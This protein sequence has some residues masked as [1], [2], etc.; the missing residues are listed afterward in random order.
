MTLLKRFL[1]ILALA[2]CL[3]CYA[4]AQR[5][6]EKPA[7]ETP[8]QVGS[9]QPEREEEIQKK[10]QSQRALGVVP[11]FTVTNRQNA[12]PLTPRQKFHLS[13]RSSFD[14]FVYVAAGLQAGIGQA[15]NQ[16]EGYGREV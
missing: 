7:T 3:S 4:A 10:E 13:V 14:P 8:A 6:T 2:S 15:T 1:C 5:D 11:L 16:F 9:S 12:P